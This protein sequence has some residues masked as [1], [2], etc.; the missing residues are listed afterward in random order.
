[1]RGRDSSQFLAKAVLD[2]DARTIEEVANKLA[3]NPSTKHLA[4]SFVANPEKRKQALFIILN[5]PTLKK[6]LAPLVSDTEDQE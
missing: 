2:G 5:N 4:D 6:M 3:Q 1:L